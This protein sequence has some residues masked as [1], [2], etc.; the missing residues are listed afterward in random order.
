MFEFSIIK[1][2]IMAHSH[3]V[4]QSIQK[5][6][7][8][9]CADTKTSRLI[10]KLKKKQIAELTSSVLALLGAKRTHNKDGSSGCLW[11]GSQGK[12]YVAGR[13]TFHCAPFSIYRVYL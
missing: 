11:E 13:L 4:L 5:N 10:I 7:S 9:Q 8:K 3:N 6:K 1:E 12:A 2:Q